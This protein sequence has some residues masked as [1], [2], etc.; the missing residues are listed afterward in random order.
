MLEFGKQSG[1]TVGFSLLSGKRE[2][3]GELFPTDDQLRLLARVMHEVGEWEDISTISP[4]IS[5]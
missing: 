2:M 3:L 1:A 5:E 4:D